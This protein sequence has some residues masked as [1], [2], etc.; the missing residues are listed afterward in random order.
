MESVLKLYE[1]YGNA[2]YIGEKVSQKE[3]ALQ[4]AYFAEYMHPNDYE[5][6]LAALFH[7]VGC[8]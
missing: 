8:Y 1:D 5:F 4:A 3:H 7:D 6:I 2:D